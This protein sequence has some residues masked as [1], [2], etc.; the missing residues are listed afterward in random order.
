MHCTNIATSTLLWDLGVHICFRSGDEYDYEETNA[1]GWSSDIWVRHWKKSF[2][3]ASSVFIGVLPSRCPT[4]LWS[5]QAERQ[6]SAESL[7]TRRAT[8]LVN[9]QKSLTMHS[10]QKCIVEMCWLSI[11]YACLDCLYTGEYLTV[12]RNGDLMINTDSDT[13]PGAGFLKLTKTY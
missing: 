1:D 8:M 6:F 9:F 3:I 11:F 7:V 12:M 4:L 5:H 10:G 13:V 2:F